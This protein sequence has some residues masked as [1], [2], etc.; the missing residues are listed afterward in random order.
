MDLNL[1]GS[2][3]AARAIGSMPQIV[4]LY[5]ASEAADG[6]EVTGRRNYS[7]V[8]EQHYKQ[9]G[10]PLVC[11]VRRGQLRPRES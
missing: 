3:A 4:R 1:A 2:K 9:L 5:A 10:S 6:T 8:R 11:R 7:G